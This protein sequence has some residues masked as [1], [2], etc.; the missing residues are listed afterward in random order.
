M[1]FNEFVKKYLGKGTDYDN[2]AGVQCVD[3]AKLYI[4]KVIGVKP[5]SI[6]DAYCYN[7]N[8]SKT[9]LKNY[10]DRIPYKHGDKPKKGDLVVWGKNY[11]GTSKYGHIAIATGDSD[12]TGIYTYDQNVGRTVTLK[13]MRKVHHSYNGIACFLRPKKNIDGKKETPKTEYYKKYTGKSVHIDEVFKAIGVLEK[14]RGSW[15]KRKAIAKANGITAY[16]GSEKQNQKLI[17]L[18]KKGKLK[19]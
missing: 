19:K 10:F 14:Y 7:D 6:G 15:N 17:D 5:Q 1:K 12:K 18:A 4:D 2:Y 9:Y 16:I 8:F 11:N 3:L 13:K